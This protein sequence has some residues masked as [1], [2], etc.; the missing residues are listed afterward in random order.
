MKCAKIYNARVQLLIYSLNLLFGDFLVAVVIVICLSSLLL[1]VERGGKQFNDLLWF[2]SLGSDLSLA[3]GLW[4]N[5]T[6]LH[7]TVMSNPL[8]II[9]EPED[10]LL[11]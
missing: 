4:N 3:R 9:P 8:S 5:R 6:K 1:I 10:G 2:G 11:I 7:V